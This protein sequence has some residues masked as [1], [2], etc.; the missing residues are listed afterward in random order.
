M[1]IEKTITNLIQLEKILPTIL[2]EQAKNFFQDSFTNQGFTDKT[3][4]KWTPSRAAKKRGGAT[5]V[6]SGRLRGSIRVTN[7][8]PSGFSVG[9][10]L[11]YAEQHNEGKK[12]QVKRQFI[13]NSERLVKLMQA[14]VN[15]EIRKAIE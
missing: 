5:L 9:T 1:S 4:V 13:G 12:G 6:Q 14:R 10:D 8:T 15:R 3:L 7:K 2:S 11:P